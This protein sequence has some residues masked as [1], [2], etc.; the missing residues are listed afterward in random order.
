M[1]TLQV[2]HSKSKNTKGLE[3]MMQ[4]MDDRS[5][6]LTLHKS[7]SIIAKLN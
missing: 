4:K 6:S 3:K 2:N 5:Q 7:A 1:Y